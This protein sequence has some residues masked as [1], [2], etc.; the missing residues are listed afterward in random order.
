VGAN[1]QTDQSCEPTGLAEDWLNEL[2]NAINADNHQGPLCRKACKTHFTGCKKTASSIHKCKKAVAK[3]TWKGVA[4]LCE[5][6]GAP[7]KACAASSKVGLK[8]EL[9]TWKADYEFDVGFCPK[10]YNVCKA[11]C[12]P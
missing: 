7:K 8:G 11:A 6:N 2:I 3:A 5:L 12:A 4:L 9:A 10:R 1:H